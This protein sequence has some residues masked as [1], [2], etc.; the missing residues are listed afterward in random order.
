[1]AD[2]QNGK[3]PATETRHNMAPVANY[4]D[5]RG[6]VIPAGTIGSLAFTGGSRGWSF[7]TATNSWSVKASDLFR[8]VK[9][10]ELAGATLGHDLVACQGCGAPVASATCCERRAA[11]SPQ[12]LD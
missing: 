8:F 1:M 11:G 4:T 12:W 9:A 7:Y 5:K 2:F 10:D 3:T 6:N